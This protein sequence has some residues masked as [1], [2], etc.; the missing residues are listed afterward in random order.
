MFGSKQLA[1]PRKKNQWCM[2]TTPLN[3][4]LVYKNTNKLLGQRRYFSLMSPCFFL[5][6]HIYNS[7]QLVYVDADIGN[8]S[9]HSSKGTSLNQFPHSHFLFSPT[10]SF[11]HFITKES[12][13]PATIKQRSRPFMT[14]KIINWEKALMSLMHQYSIIV[15]SLM[16][17]VDVSGLHV[18]TVL[19]EV[20][21]LCGSS[22]YEVPQL[23]PTQSE[24]M[25]TQYIYM[26][27]FYQ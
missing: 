7:V 13:L 15:I 2:S 27:M 25:Q 19:L 6:I 11:I 1:P 14:S 5:H 18:Q 16:K 3:Q 17:H 8:E 10:F 23:H 20:A 9:Y 4:R 21:T 12:S 24:H 22:E 26:H